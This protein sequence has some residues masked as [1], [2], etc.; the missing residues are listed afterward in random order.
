MC[1]RFFMCT[2]ANELV[3]YKA[4]KFDQ[5]PYAK[6]SFETSMNTRLI[7]VKRLQL[8]PSTRCLSFL[9]ETGPSANSLR[10]IVHQRY[11]DAPISLSYSLT[12]IQNH[13]SRRIL[14]SELCRLL[15]LILIITTI[16]ALQ[17]QAVTW[18]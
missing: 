13:S 11:L 12:I 6:T 7:R 16:H 17:S 8:E 5:T 4:S 15:T 1:K 10:L 9:F 2:L 3:T 18:L 14:Q